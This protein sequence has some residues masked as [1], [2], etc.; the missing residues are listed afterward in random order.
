MDT[1]EFMQKTLDLV[2]LHDKYVKAA[3]AL[4]ARKSQKIASTEKV[5]SIAKLLVDA[6]LIDDT[7]VKRAQENLTNPDKTLDIVRNIVEHYQGAL[8][9][10]N[11]KIASA[12]LGVADNSKSASTPTTKYSNYVGRRRGEG[13]IAA[14]DEPLR[15]LIGK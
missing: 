6:K 12:T 10:A 1:K 15:R 14:S 3:S 4:L 11:A 5:S 7:M 8:K 2:S 9:E 13:E